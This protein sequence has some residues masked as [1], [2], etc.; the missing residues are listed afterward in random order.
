MVANS[1]CDSLGDASNSKGRFLWGAHHRAALGDLPWGCSLSCGPAEPAGR[2]VL[3]RI[4]DQ[5]AAALAIIQLDGVAKRLILCPSDLFE[6]HIPSIVRRADVDIVVSD[7]KDDGAHV[8]AGTELTKSRTPN[9]SSCVTEWVLMTSGTTGEPKLVSHTLATLTAPIKQ[10]QHEEA[11][12]VWGT[13]Y[14]IHRYGGLQIFLRGLSGHGSLVL[15]DPDESPTEHL[16]RLKDRAV[17]HLTG[18]PS[19]WRRALMSPAAHAIRPRYVRLSG[20]IADQAILNS[21]RSFYPQAA[22]GHVFA[23]TEAGVAFEVN[24]GRE[25]FPESFI[26]IRGDVELKVQDGSLRI[27]SNRTATAYL[28][29]DEE[30][31][32]TDGFVDT[33][34]M[35]ELRE[36]RYH[37]LGRR[38]GVIN[39]GGS[40]VYPEEVEGLL[41]RHPAVRMSCVRSRRSSITGALVVAD[42]V[43]KSTPDADRPQAD[44]EREILALCRQTLPRH[45]VPVSLRFVPALSVAATGKI[46][47]NT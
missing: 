19:H 42:V 37:F 18:T 43:L 44:L 33:G 10:G 16:L 24:D 29:G 27:R 39:V 36:D 14:D 25:G 23:S 31:P 5:F 34:D 2:S 13:F 46:A 22:A 15:S 8:L 28:G 4:R 17:T 1:I 40:K 32:D 35:V 11:D 45:K 21:L 12:V 41:N 20:E 3:L 38:S 47:R 26:G 9:G 6:E 7:R 30:L